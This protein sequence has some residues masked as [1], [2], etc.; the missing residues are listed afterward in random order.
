MFKEKKIE[1]KREHASTNLKRQ[2]DS[3]LARSN[4]KFPDVPVGTNVL[5]RVPDVDRGR[6]TPRNFL[7]T[8]VSSNSTGLYEM[9]TKKG[10]LERQ[11]AHNKFKVA[12]DNNFLELQQ[13]PDNKIKLRNASMQLLESKQ[14]F[15]SC[16]CKKLCKKGSRG[17]CLSNGVQCNSKCHSSNSCQNK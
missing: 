7:A 2:A 6:L 16:T 9:G 17:S 8:V 11:Y 15:V 14:G 10:K 4:K 5:V 1:K 3:M 12:D 13:V